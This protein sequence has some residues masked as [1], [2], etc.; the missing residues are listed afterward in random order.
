MNQIQ[1]IIVGSAGSG[2]TTVAQFIKQALERDDDACRVKIFEEQRRPFTQEQLEG[3]DVAI[4]TT[5]WH[6]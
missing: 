6:P 1:I 2:K 5:I 3:L 4:R